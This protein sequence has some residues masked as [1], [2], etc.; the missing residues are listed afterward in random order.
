MKR[1]FAAASAFIV[2]VL[3]CLAGSCTVGK[4]DLPHR[5]D[6]SD[7][8]LLVWDLAEPRI[9]GAPDYYE[10]VSAV[11]ADFEKLHGI[12]VEVRIVSRQEVED[13]LTGESAEEKPDLVCTGEWPFIPEGAASLSPYVSC[14]SYIDIAA[15]YWETE[16]GLAAIP[17]YVHWTGTGHREEGA[18]VSYIWDSPAFMA[19]LSR[20]SKPLRDADY[21]M[22]LLQAVRSEWGE[23]RSDPLAS[24]LNGSARSLF[25]LT[26]SMYRRISAG[27]AGVSMGPVDGPVGDQ[28][29][30][31]T[32]PAYVVLAEDPETI[33]GAAELGKRLAAN[34]GRWAARALSCMPALIEDI[35]VFNLESGLDYAQRATLIGSFSDLGLTAPSV[36]E[37]CERVAQ[38][39]AMREVIGDYLSG[40]LSAEEALQGIRETLARHTKP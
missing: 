29:Y 17:A 12:E 3:A 34:L 7:T 20:S 40:R 2:V 33:A 26:P 37:Y 18:G 38:D 9:D 30:F 16:A 27:E 32:V 15:R 35:S 4:L 13:L 31:Y 24:Y 11:V 36:A 22:E 19:A 23:A 39:Q 14:D 6:F 8:A 28:Y 10:L 1:G 25:P 21:V 5:A